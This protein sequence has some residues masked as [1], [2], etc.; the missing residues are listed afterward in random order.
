MTINWIKRA[1]PKIQELVP[2]RPGKSH[3]AIAREL[4]IDGLIKLA[5][6]ENPRGPGPA[7]R[8]AVRE[9]MDSLRLYP[10]QHDLVQALSRKLSVPPECITLGNGSNDA[11]DL[12][13]RVFLAP[14]RSAIVS[15]YC[16]LVYPLVVA[17]AGAELI[18][19]PAAQYGHDLKEMRAAV[20]NT[21]SLMYIA[22]P[23]N[24]TGTSFSL[25]ALEDLLSEIPKGVVVVLDEAYFEYVQRSNYPNGLTLLQRYENLVV[26]RTF[27]KVYGLASARIGYAVSNPKIA[28]LLNRARQPFNANGMAMVAALAA[29]NDGSFVDSS[30]KLNRAGITQLVS[31]LTRMQIPFIPSAGNF[32]SFDA[33]MYLGVRVSNLY[34]DLLKQGVIVRSLDNYQ[35]PNHLRVTIGLSDENARFLRA[36]TSCL[37]AAIRR[38]E[39]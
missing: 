4:G 14:G 6:N 15:Q 9:H 11:L 28:D 19:V 13:A 27:S 30:V 34:Q 26:T 3:D 18:E 25:Q 2:Y 39:S 22:N 37:E 12:L 17:L 10:D 31:G 1:N 24:P 23:N 5:S 36:L 16:F 38:K 32:I 8:D 29:L 33:S 21:T 35:L 7:V 20:R